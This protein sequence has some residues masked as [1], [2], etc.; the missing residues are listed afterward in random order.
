MIPERHPGQSFDEHQREMAEWMGFDGPGA[1]DAMNAGHDLL[2]ARLCAWLGITSFALKHARGEHL[3]G[4]EQLLAGYEEAAVL[5]V[6]R[7]MVC[8]GRLK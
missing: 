5:H 1:V 6:Q 8:H 4:R 2:H 3:N 7:L